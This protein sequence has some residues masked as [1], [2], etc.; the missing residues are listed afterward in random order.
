MSR[1]QEDNIA[2]NTRVDARMAQSNRTLLNIASVS[3]ASLLQ[4]I[5]QFLFFSILAKLYGA[6]AE[7][8]ALAAALA[9]PTF[10]AAVITGSL[11]Y[12]LIPELVAKFE[13]QE[14][15]HEA[16]QLA[17]YVG[18][19]TFLVSALVGVFLFFGSA[20][21]CTFVYAK[22]SEPD[23][24]LTAKLLRI[25]S[26]QVALTGLISWA[27]S[28]NHSRHQF[29]MPAIGGVAGTG[30]SLVIAMF[31]G[32]VSIIVIAWAINA[33][34][35]VS[36]VLHVLPLVGK[37]TKPKANTP[38][39]LRLGMLLWPLILGAAFIRVDP[40]VDRVL[41][42]GDEGA[43]AHINYAQRIM[44]ALLAI[45][46]STLALIAFPQLKQRLTNEGEAGFADHLAL[47]SRRLILVVVPV[48]AGFSVF[49][50]R[51]I[52]DLLQRGEFTAADSQTVG[53]LVIALM[54]MFIGASAG[55][56]IARAFYT[57]GDTRT[58]TVLG[59]LALV[60][61]LVVKIALFR[62]IGIW[63]IAIGV[64]FYYLLSMGLMA[65]VLM[66][67]V[68]RNIFAGCGIYFLHAL[69][70]S[71]VACGCCNWIYATKLGSTWVAGPVGVIVYAFGLLAVRNR[72]AWYLIEIVKQ[73]L[74]RG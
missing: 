50:V 12:V 46:S 25:L 8:D 70:G 7:A 28:V 23:L 65:W 37:L 67:R 43:I 31:Y 35:A 44:M 55:D 38:N 11:A 2:F 10:A 62:Q 36:V 42:S 3:A 73:R 47:A 39:L 17:S 49:S 58:P 16:W 9:L 57:L 21:V 20:T 64:S 45:G 53:Y 18:A 26:L 32:E 14:K 61:A 59:A 1:A 40:I 29:M 4:I 5:N 54:G 30:L 27:Q 60:I 34:S 41:A 24:A 52:S 6:A 51:I 48:V 63:G 74:I 66:R 68:Q 69:V 71:A 56:L 33:G 15:Q 22:M 13:N 72:D 19:F